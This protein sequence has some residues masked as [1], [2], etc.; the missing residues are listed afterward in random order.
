[1][2]DKKDEIMERLYRC[3]C[4]A[5]GAYGILEPMRHQLP[6]YDSC[7]Q[8]LN[9]AIAAYEDYQ[10][11]EDHTNCKFFQIPQGTLKEGWCDLGDGRTGSCYPIDC[12]FKEEKN[13]E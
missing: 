6:G 2:Q 12:A 5:T 1:M 9:D 8:S 4:N 11:R 10:K 3:C 13:H 7:K